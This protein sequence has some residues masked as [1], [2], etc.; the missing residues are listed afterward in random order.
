MRSPTYLLT[1]V[2]GLATNLGVAST[3]DRITVDAGP[4]YSSL[5]FP[6]FLHTDEG[7][8]ISLRYST[9]FKEHEPILST[10]PRHPAF[11]LKEGILTTKGGSFVAHYGPTPAIYPPLLL[12]LR[13]SSRVGPNQAA[14]FV[15]VT[16]AKGLRLWAL[17]GCRC[18]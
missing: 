8:N 12:P 15:A 16:E 7:F 18:K 10:G 9:V 6:F 13:L 1:C 2:L 5:D 4:I 17:L 11:V 14:R 3:P